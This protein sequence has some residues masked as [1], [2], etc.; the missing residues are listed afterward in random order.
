MTNEALIP[1]SVLLFFSFCPLTQDS[2][3][4]SQNGRILTY[5]MTS[6]KKVGSGGRDPPE[7]NF[8]PEVEVLAWAAT[9]YNMATLA[10]GVI[11]DDGVPQRNE[12]PRRLVNH[13]LESA[14]HT[15]GF[16]AIRQHVRREP[17]AP[18]H[19]AGIERMPDFF[20]RLYLYPLARLQIQGLQRGLSLFSP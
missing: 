17:E 16:P 8:P 6:F 18:V 5:K 7:P 1:S 14:Q 9:L 2:I 10:D 20:L 15:I 19:S 4:N 12:F 3:R 11:E 13:P